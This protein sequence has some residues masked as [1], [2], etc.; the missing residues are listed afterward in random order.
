MS[1]HEAVIA[2]LDGA[3]PLPPHDAD[4]PVFAEPWQAQ[5]FAMAVAL[6]QRGI[7]TWPEWAAALAAE[8]AQAAGDPDGGSRYYEHW[9]A[10]L[11]RLVLAKGVADAEALGRRK[12]AWDR[13][14]R[15]TPHGAPILL[16]NDPLSGH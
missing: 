4:G 9:M 3:A 7:F 10:A 5:A 12:N 11:E 2:A 13:A 14:A 15:A 1:R 8:I 16:E 6:H